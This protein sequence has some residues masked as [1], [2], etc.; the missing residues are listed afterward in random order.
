MEAAHGEEA[1]GRGED[2]QEPGREEGAVGSGGRHEGL[3]FVAAF[4]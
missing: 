1:G 3:P 4:L 2:G